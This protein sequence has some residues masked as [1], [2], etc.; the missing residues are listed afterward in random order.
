M[1]YPQLGQ[2]CISP[3]W[4]DNQA[5]TKYHADC[6]TRVEAR[7]SNCRII[8]MG[9]LNRLK[10]SCISSQFKLETTKSSKASRCDT[11]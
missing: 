11:N 1:D 2:Q 3:P 9:D 7:Y 6:L 10:K 4:S 5:R 8:I